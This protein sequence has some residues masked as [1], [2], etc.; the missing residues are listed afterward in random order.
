MD[1]SVFVEFVVIKTDD[2]VKSFHIKRA[3]NEATDLD[4][5]VTI[6]PKGGSNCAHVDVSTTRSYPDD[7][8]VQSDGQ[9]F[10]VCQPGA[11]VIK[12]A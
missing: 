10:E 9:K 8:A 1:I 5:D 12:L 11:D 4:I 3:E 2:G 6:S 7:G